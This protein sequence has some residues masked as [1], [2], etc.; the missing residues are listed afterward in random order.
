ML[1]PSD[2]HKLEERGHSMIYVNEENVKF[3]YDNNCGLEKMPLMNNINDIELYER[4]L[5]VHNQC[6]IPMTRFYR[7]KLEDENS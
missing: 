6:D 4:L 5:N 1:K 3:F 7:L 2:N